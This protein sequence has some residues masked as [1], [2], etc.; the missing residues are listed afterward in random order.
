MS[1]LDYLRV[2]RR[3]WIAIVLLTVFGAA[4]GGAYS[5]ASDPSYESA[6]KVF[7][8]TQTGG[9]L[10]ELSEGTSYS[11]QVVSSY[12]NVATTPLVLDPVIDELDLQET[13]ESLA[14]RVTATS[15][16]GT[17]VIDIT[18]SDA[19]AEGAAAIANAVAA[20][21][22]QAVTTLTG[23]EAEQSPVRITVIQPA[24]VPLSP[25]SPNAP[26][27]LALGALIGLAFGVIVAVV[28]EAVDVRVRGEHDIER[29][30]DKPLLGR[31]S[32]DRSARTQ[33]LVALTNPRSV[34]AEA[35]RTLRTNLQFL[36]ISR[37]T[38]TIVITSAREGE[39]KTTTATNLAITV[40][41]TGNSTLLID[42]DLRRPRVSNYLGI[43]GGIGLTDVLIGDVTLDEALQEWGDKRM[44]VLP[45]G[46]I[47]PNPSELL[48][49][50][51]MVSMLATLKKRFGTIII[52]APPLLPVSDAAILGVRSSGVIVVA[53]A[54][55]VTRD[56]LKRALAITD[57]VGARVLGVVLGMLPRSGP[58]ANGY[59][60]YT[61][62]PRRP[63][64]RTQT[65]AAVAAPVD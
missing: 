15:T 2:L 42:A 7:V 41:D 52:D 64:A 24:T 45:A 33:P 9:S 16:L 12:A 54:R 51:A 10:P 48:Q 37:G 50:P 43:D 47:P 27:N 46:Q 61:S 58:D 65:S 35:F 3:S 31:I 6:T 21:L 13:A 55:K 38:R 19:T 36:D 29:V 14:G 40:A 44:M 11:Q 8:S 18:A 17:V 32:R 1:L 26:L 28:R 59:G 34:R 60:A 30:T 39:G 22:G 4:A 49:G 5:L 53:A 56:Q 62:E 25:A 23:A 63:Q 20:S 57:Q